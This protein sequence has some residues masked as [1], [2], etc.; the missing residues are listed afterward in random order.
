MSDKEILKTSGTLAPP[1]PAPRVLIAEL[2]FTT[3]SGR[4][5]IALAQAATEV[6]ATPL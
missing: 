3:P 6:M 4:V 2:R 1:S 5:E